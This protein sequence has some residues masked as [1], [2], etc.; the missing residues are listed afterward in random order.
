MARKARDHGSNGGSV[1]SLASHRE[2]AEAKSNAALEGA[3]LGLE[4][5][6]HVGLSRRFALRFNETTRFIFDGASVRVL[7][8]DG[9]RWTGDQTGEVMR[10]AREVVASMYAEAASLPDQDDRKRVAEFAR[11][12]ESQGSLRAMVALA[13][14]EP[15]LVARREDFDR[16]QWLLNTPSGTVDLRTGRIRPHDR[17]DLITKITGVPFDPAAKAPTWESHLRYFLP[18]A[19]VRAFVLRFLGYALTGVIREHAIAIFWGE[20]DNGK[21]TTLEVVRSALGDYAQNP[22]ADVILAKREN[23]PGNDVARLVGVRLAT[24]VETEESA[25]L[26][27]SLLKRL[28]G[29]DRMTARFLYGEFFEFDPTA[30][31]VLSTNHRPNIRGTDHAIWRRIN[32]V[33][34]TVKIPEAEKNL[35]I[36]ETL[37]S[38]GAG[39]LAA[40]VRGCL[41]WQKVGLRPPETVRAATKSYREAEDAVGRFI[42]DLCELADD[43][44]ILA[45]PLYESYTYWCKDNGEKYPL[46]QRRFGARLTER[47]LS[48]ERRESKTG[49][50]LWTGIRLRE[51][52]TRKYTEGL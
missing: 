38:E 23:G 32:L 44:T 27:E 29:G 8:W 6:T 26:R 41:E 18:E 13:A 9:T 4:H 20:G 14:S 40:L 12:S 15:E 22:P 49:R 33:P 42:T 2:R 28:S 1:A 11:K 45:T 46:T 37:R 5:L 21:S 52:P 43:A 47:G 36:A 50:T 51:M 7:I 24:V 39:I 31:F 17:A 34:F 25:R 3:P 16:D 35:A 30:K 48:N 19:A 10:L